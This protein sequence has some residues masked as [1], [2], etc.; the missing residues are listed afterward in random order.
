MYCALTKACLS[1]LCQEMISSSAVAMHLLAV[2]QVL[3][4]DK[5]MNR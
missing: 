4:T 5:S 1:G 2:E 3:I